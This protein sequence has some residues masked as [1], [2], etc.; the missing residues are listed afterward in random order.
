LFIIYICG[1]LFIIYICG[2]LFI[3]YICGLLFI[4]YICGLLFIIY[5]IFIVCYLL[6]R[7]LASS[8]SSFLFS[9]ICYWSKCNV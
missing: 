9:I 1:L 3:I 8:F 5:I 4:I 7:L 6:F 2:L